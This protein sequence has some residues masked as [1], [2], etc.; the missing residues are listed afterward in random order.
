MTTTTTTIRILFAL[1]FVL[2][3]C[4]GQKNTTTSA[5]ELT[6]T[7]WNYSDYEISY[8]ISF[9]KDGIY[10]STHPNDKTYGND[11]WKQ[12]GKKVM[13]YSNDKY[14]TYTGEFHGIDSIVG[15]ATNI[16]NAQ[17]TFT[18]ARTK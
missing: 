3:S 17:W 1:A 16:E 11:T 12:S 18:L 10:T 7:K 15:T 9:L 2:T 5:N 6:G 8:T 14:A 4:V 13:F